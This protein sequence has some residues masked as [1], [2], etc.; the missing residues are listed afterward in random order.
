LITEYRTPKV[1][2]KSDRLLQSYFACKGTDRQ[3]NFCGRERIGSDWQFFIL[4]A[5]SRS[6]DQHL[7]WSGSALEVR[8]ASAKT[9]D[10]QRLAGELRFTLSWAAADT[11]RISELSVPFGPMAGRLK[12]KNP[13][14][15]E[16][17]LDRPSFPQ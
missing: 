6:A 11:S 5:P 9:L 10:R 16:T 14:A 15:D 2:S 13:F 8:E 12:R 7:H 3:W 1:I 17:N 4:A